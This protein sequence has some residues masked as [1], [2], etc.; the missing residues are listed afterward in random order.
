MAYYDTTRTHYRTELGVRFACHVKRGGYTEIVC[1][2][3]GT[4]AP[5]IFDHSAFDTHWCEVELRK[6]LRR[7]ARQIRKLHKQEES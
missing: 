3:D 1:L 6:M 7:R 2:D 5:M 4:D